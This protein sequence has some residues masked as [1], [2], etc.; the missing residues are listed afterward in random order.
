MKAVTGVA[1]SAVALLATA[2]TPE[3]VIACALS[4]LSDAAT[5]LVPNDAAHP[6][7]VR[8]AAKA[9]VSA[10]GVGLAAV[11]LAL[12]GYEGASGWPDGLH[13]AGSVWLQLDSADWQTLGILVARTALVALLPNGPRSSSADTVPGEVL[14]EQA[15]ADIDPALLSDEPMHL[16][17]VTVTSVLSAVPAARAVPADQAAALAAR[18][19]RAVRRQVKALTRADTSAGRHEAR[20]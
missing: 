6:S 19:T 7:W 5:W 8:R 17:P 1:G 11:P 3:Q 16:D 9:C 2:T 18:P 15:A 12:S 20:R 14:H 10:A 4:G 13:V